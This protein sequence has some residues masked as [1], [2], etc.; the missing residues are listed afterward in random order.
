MTSLG[1]AENS[2]ELMLEVGKSLD[3]HQRQLLKTFYDRRSVAERYRNGSI[4][5]HIHWSAR[6]DF[7]CIS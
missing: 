2:L 3:R 4:A 7:F 1:E 5:I 6:E